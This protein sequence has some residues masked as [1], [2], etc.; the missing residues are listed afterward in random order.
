MRQ[1]R[2]WLIA[3]ILLP[4]LFFSGCQQRDE[5][6]DLAV[7][8]GAFLQL[9][10]NGDLQ[11][12][13][14]VA[15]KATIDGADESLAFSVAAATWQEAERA[16]SDKLDKTVYWGHMVLIV[17]GPGFSAEQIGAYMAA[18]YQDQRFSPVIYVALTDAESQELLEASFGEAAYLSQGLAERLSWLSERQPQAS[19]TVRKYMQNSY[20][21]HSGG[22][23]A[24]LA[25]QDGQIYLSGMVDADEREG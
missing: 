6:G 17:F 7:V 14:E 24:L 11:M 13:V 9:Q 4:G 2:K 5:I 18:F 22:T 23:M 20:Y 15:H 12:S 3:V 1:S 8:L 21:R 25:Q 10:E 19:L 16:L